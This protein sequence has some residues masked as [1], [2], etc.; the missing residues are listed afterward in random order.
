[1]LVS[2]IISSFNY[3]RYIERAIRSALDQS[4]DRTRY[5]IIVIDDA[6]TDQTKHVLEN[7]KDEVRVIQFEKN[8]G[9]SAVRNEGIKKAKGQFVVFL[10]ADDYI[11]HDLL[12]LQSVFLSENNQLN[13][14]SVNYYLVDEY[15]NHI[16]NV[17][18]EKKLLPAVSCFVKICCSILVFTM[19]LSGQEKMKISAS[20]FWKSMRSIILFFAI[21]I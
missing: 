9:L 15:G 10:D 13:A 17:D 7:Y 16:E 2:V 14:V 8:K 12:K 21:Q 18:A 4:L 1:M 19:N 6:S 3:A 11:Q 5:E 20:G